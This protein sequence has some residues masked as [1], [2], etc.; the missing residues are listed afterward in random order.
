MGGGI[1]R[2]RKKV[3]LFFR[4]NPCLAL[5]FQNL[6][7]ER[8]FLQLFVSGGINPLGTGHS[9]ETDTL[10][11][12]LLKEVHLN[13]PDADKGLLAVGNLFQYET[14]YAVVSSK[15]WKICSM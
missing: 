11:Q 9:A 14:G 12:M 13:I 7:I 10:C 6:R 5:H 15:K 3:G 4:V 2:Y 1:F 8:K